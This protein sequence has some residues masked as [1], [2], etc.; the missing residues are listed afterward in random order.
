MK[1]AFLLGSAHV[2]G[3]TY[4]IFQ[5]A[6]FLAR[7]GWDV[8]IV[9]LDPIPSG[10]TLWHPEAHAELRYRTHAEVVDEVFDVAIATWWRT[11]YRLH[12]IKARSYQYFVQ[13]IESRFFEDWDLA[14]RWYAEATYTMQLPVITEA[15]WI[16]EYLTSR[17]GSS[18]HMAINGIRKDIYRP[19]G[20][21]VAPRDPNRLR[22]L[23]EGPLRVFFKNVERTIEL[24]KK[25]HADEIWLL[26]S[27]SDCT[28]YPGIDR[29][30]SCIPIAEVAS[31]Y[32]SCDVI[33]KL[34]HV[35]GMFGPPLEMFHCGGTAVVYQV[36]GHEEYIVEGVNAIVLPKDD[37]EGVIAAINDFK[38]YPEKLRQ[39]KS[40]ALKTAASWPDWSEAS[41]NFRDGI[42]KNAP[43]ACETQE[44]L[45]AKS[46]VFSGWYD[47]HLGVQSSL[48]TIA[49]QFE[50]AKRE[51]ENFRSTSATL[52]L[53][54]NS[55][56]FRF[57]Q[58]LRGLG[59][60]KFAHS[61]F[62][63]S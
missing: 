21:A 50:A 37:E 54:L 19:E 24:C 20:E 1:I 13:S 43:L 33:V 39:L 61:L 47:G 52:E 51:S 53:I 10:Q 59:A 15:S 23:V 36:T 16:K 56:S 25:S 40:N 38:R 28:N 9:T 26:T 18:V 32:R 17:F 58:R 12:L 48:H 27:S 7:S 35:E 2:G 44:S 57:M 4:V 8:T 60:T 34:S 42:I 49:P 55:R 46:E 62:R 6:L 30:F 29:T 45:R 3:G 11:A 22:V 14:A 41:K 31:V 5:H 63:S